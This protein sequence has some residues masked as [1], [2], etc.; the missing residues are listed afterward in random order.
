MAAAVESMRNIPTYTE[1]ARAAGVGVDAIRRATKR[2]EVFAVAMH[3]ARE[4][5]LDH[6]EETIILRARSGQPLV[7]TVVREFTDGTK[8]TTTT[9]ERHISDNLAMFYLKRWR[10]EYR[11]SY[12]IEQTGA[13]GG[14]IRI[15]QEA[16]IADAVGLFDAEVVRL[17]A[18]GEAGEATP[19]GSGQRRSS[20]S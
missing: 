10:P 15:E 7:K 4:E 5:G 16:K 11:D 1:A 3:D 20:G 2:D 9:T 17:A 8:E 13:N 18:A 6:L 12:R 14:P 19:A